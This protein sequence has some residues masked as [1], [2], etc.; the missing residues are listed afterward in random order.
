MIAR[1]FAPCAL[2]ALLIACGPGA[3]P[4][5]ERESYASAAT[6]EER[7]YFLYLPRGYARDR[8]PRWPVLLFLHGGG[9]RGDGKGDLDHVLALGPLYEAWVQRRELPFVIVAPQLPMFGRDR[10][11]DYLKKRE[12]SRLPRRLAA[13]TPPRRR[14][15]RPRR[16]MNGARADTSLPSGPTGLPDGWPRCEQDLLAILD[17]TLAEHRVDPSRVYLTGVSYG[18]FGTWHLASR[19]P[20][21][22]AAIVPVVAWGHPDLMPSLAARRMPL[23]VF[24][25]GRDRVIEPRFF[26]PGLNALE[27]AGHRGVRFTIHEDMAHDAFDRVYAGSDVY[28]WLLTHRLTPSP[29]SEAL[30]EVP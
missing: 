4:R 26:Y 21:R 27:R 12:G 28:D 2:V 10:V 8:G 20:H 14:P 19:H 18:G 29:D 7:D 3:E 13:G 6:G 17:R 25:G 5:L 24:A 30:G 22:F 9:E 15:K 1:L 16:P 11:D 23:W